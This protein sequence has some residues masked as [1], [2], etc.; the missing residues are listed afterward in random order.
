MSNRSDAAETFLAH[1]ESSQA[2]TILPHTM[3]ETYTILSCMYDRQDKA[4]YL[5]A[6]KKSGKQ[7]LLK[8][9]HHTSQRAPLGVEHERLQSLAKAFPGEY[10]GSDY[11]IE[12]ETEYLLRPYIDGMNL[13][14]YQ[15]SNHTLPLQEVLDIGIQICESISR[16][17]ALHPPILHRD[18]KPQNL[19][20]GKDGRIHLIDFET[21]REYK[22]NHSK[23]TVFLGTEGTAPPEQ[24]GFSQ[25]DV[26]SDI[27][28]IGKVLEYLYEENKD[29]RTWALYSAR[30]KQLLQNLIQTATAF[31]PA[32]RYQHVPTLQHALQKILRRIDSQMPRQIPMMGVLNLIAMAVLVAATVFMSDRFLRVTD[33][34]ETG[35]EPASAQGAAQT[36]DAPKKASSEQA[37][38]DVPVN[39]SDTLTGNTERITFDGTVADGAART[40]GK[41]SLS[42]KDF[43]TITSIALIGNQVYFTEQDG[44]ILRELIDTQSLMEDMINGGIDDI[45]V[46]T[47]MKNL[48]EVF[49]CMQRITDISP[50]KDLPIEKLYLCGNQITDFS[51]IESMENLTTLCIGNNPASVLPDFRKCPRLL[52]LY[53]NNNIYDDL[54][55]LRNTNIG[56]LNIAE[57]LIRNKDFGPLQEMKN[58]TTLYTSNNQK[59]LYDT[60]R[61]L[62]ELTCLSLWGYSVENN[63]SIIKDMP[64]LTQLLLGGDTLTNMDGILQASHLEQLCIDGT[65]IT[66]LSLLPELPRL[67]FVKINGNAIK[68]FSPFLQCELL[69]T[70]SADD[71]QKKIITD[72]APTLPFS[73]TDR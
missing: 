64:H 17:H 8:S 30:N 6:N 48:K 72:M 66:D 73:L 38:A 23:D 24:Y 4:C 41:T 14:E 32:N 20:V 62:R 46:M 18:I 2:D 54:N 55:M 33:N 36:S 9:G 15:E 43:E 70:V 61:K 16:L 39:Q 34:G 65:A 51:P 10:A 60:V 29:S 57:T 71:R 5:M 67:R 28:G 25:T 50:L 40:M 52:T 3:L 45:S 47:K 56:T 22:E 53:L 31:D 68:D 58:L 11:W 26:R 69:Q 63:L 37:P 1:F 19:I 21:A 35:Q 49:L 59:E 44:E 7:Y 13:E 12:N 42:D 27:Y